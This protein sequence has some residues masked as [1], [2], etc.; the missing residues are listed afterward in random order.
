MRNLLLVH[1]ALKKKSTTP[2]IL[3][4]LNGGS[5]LIEAML[6]SGAD[7]VSIDHRTELTQTHNFIQQNARRVLLTRKPRPFLSIC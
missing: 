2:I 6:E 1:Y 4:N 5:H 3:D 7:V